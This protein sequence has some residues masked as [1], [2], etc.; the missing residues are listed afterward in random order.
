MQVRASCRSRQE[1]SWTNAASTAP[2]DIP[3]IH[4]GVRSRELAT[5][6][7]CTKGR[8]HGAGGYRGL[9]MPGVLDAHR[10]TERG[11]QLPRWL[12][13]CWCC[14]LPTAGTGPLGTRSKFTGAYRMKGWIIRLTNWHSGLWV[15]ADAPP[16]GVAWTGNRDEAMRFDHRSEAL[17]WMECR[18]ENPDGF[19]VHFVRN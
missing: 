16:N 4:P 15:R 2:E 10:A 3:A 18:R 8:Q 17:Y 9:R 14:E 19:K 6:R 7:N 12:A 5:N 11:W 13:A 1:T